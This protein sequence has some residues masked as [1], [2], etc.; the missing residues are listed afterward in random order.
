MPIPSPLQVQLK[1]GGTAFLLFPN[2]PPGDARVIDLLAPEALEDLEETLTRDLQEP[3]ALIRA[4]G[5]LV[6]FALQAKGEEHYAEAYAGYRF[7]L[8]LGAELR[9]SDLLDTIT[10]NIWKLWIELDRLQ[11]GIYQSG[12]APQPATATIPVAALIP[13][14]A[15]HIHDLVISD[16]K[17][18]AGAEP[19]TVLDWE[20][21][22]SQLAM[23]SGDWAAFT[24]H[25]KRIERLSTQPPRAHLMLAV[26]DGLA[27][28]SLADL[29]ALLDLIEAD[30]K[31]PLPMRRWWNL[32]QQYRP[33]LYLADDKR[34]LERLLHLVYRWQLLRQGA[35][36]GGGAFGHQLSYQVS[37]LLQPVCRDAISLQQYAGMTV[38]ALE[39]V[40]DTL[41]KALV[42]WM[43]RTHPTNRL[44]VN[45]QST[46]ANKIGGVRSA[47]GGEIAEVARQLKA[48]L[49]YYLDDLHGFWCWLVTP[50]GMVHPARIDNAG[51][52]LDA[53]FR[54]LALP[55]DPRE[56]GRAAPTEEW[57]G[58]LEAAP[59]VIDELLHLL[60][61]RLFP[62][63]IQEV[64]DQV[65]G[66]KLVIIPDGMLHFVPF[67]ALQPAA[68]GFLVEAREI[69]Y[70]P[71]ATAWLLTEG[72][73]GLY[74]LHRQRW[75]DKA[76][77]WEHNLGALDPELLQ[78]VLLMGNIDYRNLELTVN[79]RTITLAPLPGSGREIEAISRIVPDAARFEGLHASCN[80]LVKYGQGA[81]I[82]HL[83]SHGIVP[84][85]APM[86]SCIV[87]A[88]GIFTAAY[89]YEFDPGLRARLFVLSA[90]DTALGGQHQDSLISLTNAL[91]VAGANAV[92]STLWKIPDRATVEL[93]KAFYNGLVADKTISAALRAAQC[94]MLAQPEYAHPL[95]W[96]A[97]KVTGHVR[98][99]IK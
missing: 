53:L 18:L 77:T 13:E 88:D 24:L 48:P 59:E 67:A 19:A 73:V 83:A 41:S 86:D 74:D 4:G 57:R 97:F 87:L 80:N 70:L 69:L 28:A 31:A 7:P 21:I 81:A 15:R 78:P 55:T 46:F 44:T 23:M 2:R 94:Q 25:F 58:T 34:I 90:C 50:E 30:P 66:E 47:R 6:N 92:C 95:Y 17:L 27:Q 85:N 9:R 64:L 22:L 3:E 75:L 1:I 8:W 43:A 40:E 84:V 39:G 45:W 62:P 99:P 60:Y 98:N 61:N 82:V 32:Y 26:L 52:E 63:E 72:N 20:H 51:G 91:L 12:A 68:G 38:A 37:N 33:D 93:M 10:Y 71:S 29:L 11:H 96:G 5:M 35:T 36:S 65:Q 54:A 49:L 76:A 89:L 42:D 56:A 79:G 14:D 16:Q